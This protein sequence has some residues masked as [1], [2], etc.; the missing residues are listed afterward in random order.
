MER[1]I[2]IF[3]QGWEIVQKGIK[4]VLKDGPGSMS[5]SVTSWKLSHIFVFGVVPST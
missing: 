3:E 1:K 2:I 4:T 5:I